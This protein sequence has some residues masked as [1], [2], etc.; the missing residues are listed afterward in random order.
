MQKSL[1][2]MQN[3]RVQFVPVIKWI[4]YFLVEFRVSCINESMQIVTFPSPRITK[5][6]GKEWTP[7]V[8]YCCC[9]DKAKIWRLIYKWLHNN[10]AWSMKRV[11]IPSDKEK[12]Q[13]T[14][15]NRDLYF[16]LHHSKYALLI[17]RLE[18]I[19]GLWCFIT[20]CPRKK[21]GLGRPWLLCVRCPS[22]PPPPMGS[23]PGNNKLLKIVP[24][25]SSRA[26]PLPNVQCRPSPP[27][28][29]EKEVEK[30]VYV[31]LLSP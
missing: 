23:L 14:T 2:N 10:N 15:F 28:R 26:H 9:V 20:P 7:A 12:Q 17:Q 24:F 18:M 1:L 27:L 31:T 19:S 11:W 8:W 29:K 4:A 22:M 6:K 5:V 21:W 3:N 16:P 30:L 25:I 13:H